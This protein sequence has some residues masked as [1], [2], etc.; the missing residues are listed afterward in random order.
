MKGARELCE[1]TYPNPAFLLGI[2]TGNIE[3]CSWAKLRRARLDSFFSFG[4]F[5]SDSSDRTQLVRIA[6]ERGR[7]KK[8]IPF[9]EMKV[10]LIGDSSNDILGFHV[11]KFIEPGFSRHAPVA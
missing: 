3:A 1:R 11:F 10:F 4:G 7:A 8:N 5:G 2:Q 6:I 9:E